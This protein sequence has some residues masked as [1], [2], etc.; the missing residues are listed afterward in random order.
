VLDRAE[1]LGGRTITYEANGWVNDLGG[2]LLATSYQ[3]FDFDMPTKLSRASRFEFIARF[4][5]RWLLLLAS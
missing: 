1:R 3:G 5:R 2:S 4:L